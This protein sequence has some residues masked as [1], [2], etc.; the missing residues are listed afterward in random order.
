MDNYFDMPISIEKFAAY[1]DGNL[2]QDEINNIDSI[3]GGNPDMEALVSMSDVVDE[4][5]QHYINDDFLYEADM[6]ALEN[7]DFELWEQGLKAT[8]ANHLDGINN[9]NNNLNDT[10]MEREIRY[11]N[12]RIGEE[13]KIDVSSDVYQWY[14]DTCVIK[15]Q[16]LVLEKYGVFVSQEELIEVATKNGWYTKGGGTPM[17]YVGNL[18]DYYG[19]PSTSVVDA[20]VNNIVAELAQGHQVIVGIDANE[21]HNNKFVESLKDYF[22]ETPNHAL[23]VAG[24][25]TSD[26]NQTYVILKDPGTGDVAKPYPIEQFIDAWE[27]SSCFMVSTND[28]AY[29]QFSPELTN[30]DYQAM[31]MD[32]ICGVPFDDYL[33]MNNVLSIDDMCIIDTNFMESWKDYWEDHQDSSQ[34][35]S[36]TDDQQL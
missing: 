10:I 26:P 27:D 15:S 18:L 20:S 36:N 6:T 17:E 22:S 14:P 16:Q 5:V 24:I 19:V 9:I 7:G 30:F 3:I 33:D 35:E 13:P 23:I 28:P 4:D 25:D 34:I 29:P 8:I 11:A 12:S 2:P 32:N 31:H 1:L 21:L